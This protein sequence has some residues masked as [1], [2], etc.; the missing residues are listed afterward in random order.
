[1]A[2][3]TIREGITRETT[4]DEELR[5]ILET[6]KAEIK[7]VGVGGAGNNTISR[8]MAVGIV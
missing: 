5:K 7:V 2:E 3:L 8:L 6:R 4:D 1:M